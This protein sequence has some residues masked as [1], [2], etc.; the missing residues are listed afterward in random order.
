ML[1]SIHPAHGQEPQP[2]NDFRSSQRLVPSAQ[3]PV[4]ATDEP[5]PVP[6]ASPLGTILSSSA[7]INPLAGDANPAGVYLIQGRFGSETVQRR[8]VLMK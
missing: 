3:R 1:C 2:N 8:V 6:D 7:Q 4:P 5:T